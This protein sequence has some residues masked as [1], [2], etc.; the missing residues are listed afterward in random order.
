MNAS[1][2]LI[3][4]AV[5]FFFLASSVVT[6]SL[7]SHT[8]SSADY[9]RGH[10][11]ILN[12]CYKALPEDL[13]TRF[14]WSKTDNTLT[15]ISCADLQGQPTAQSIVRNCP[16]T[17]DPNL[18]ADGAAFKLLPCTIVKQG[19]GCTDPVPEYLTRLSKATT[20]E[21]LSDRD[22]FR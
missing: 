12:P 5:I 8:Y 15:I 19:T 22:N 17:L 16:Y 10:S 6:L 13:H 2:N 21:L 9:V 18:T 4:C 20:L 1:R 11:Q 7:S 3:G 14:N